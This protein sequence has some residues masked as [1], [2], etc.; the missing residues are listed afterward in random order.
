MRPIAFMF[1]CIVHSVQVLLILRWPIVQVPSADAAG[2]HWHNRGGE[3]YQGWKEE[4]GIMQWF[5]K[6]LCMS[7]KHLHNTSLEPFPRVYNSKQIQVVKMNVNNSLPTI[8][9]DAGIQSWLSL[10][11]WIIIQIKKKW[12]AF[13]MYW[14]SIVSGIHAREWISPA[15][16]LFFI[17]KMVKRMNKGKGQVVQ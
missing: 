9:I 10:P 2:K 4:Y 15:S 3:R 1:I 7:C 6:I 16:I 5:S 14:R 13:A 8:F 17:E 11:Y 12:S